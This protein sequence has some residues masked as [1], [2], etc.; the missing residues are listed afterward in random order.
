M[1][2]GSC[3]VAAYLNYTFS[4]S[5]LMFGTHAGSSM[6]LMKEMEVGLKYLT[7]KNTIIKTEMLEGETEML[8]FSVYVQLSLES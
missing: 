4:N 5:V 7:G 8:G 6:D 3:K 2:D 1:V